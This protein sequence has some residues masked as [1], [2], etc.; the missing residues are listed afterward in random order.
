[1]ATL[2]QPTPMFMCPPATEANAVAASPSTSSPGV[3]APHSEGASSSAGR[4]PRHPRPLRRGATATRS[5]DSGR[6]L[7]VLCNKIFF[8]RKCGQMF[9]NILQNIIS[10]TMLNIGLQPIMFEHWVLK[11]CV[12]L[13]PAGGGNETRESRNLLERSVL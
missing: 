10:F 7:V 8:L 2:S 9:Q 11:G 4:C 3:P 1:M 12:N 5:S 6:R 13:S